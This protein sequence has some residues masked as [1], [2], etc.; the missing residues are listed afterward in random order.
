MLTIK[1]YFKKVQ[2]ID[3]DSL[4]ATLREGYDFVSE[5]TEDHTRWDYYHADEEIRA[6]IDRFLADLSDH[7]NKATAQPGAAAVKES[8]EK[9][10][11]EAAKNLI[12]PYVLRGDRMEALNKSHLSASGKE[13]SASIAGGKIN[14]D[15]VKGVPVSYK[16][17]LHS[18]YTELLEEAGMKPPAPQRSPRKTKLKPEP[19]AI[20]KPRTSNKNAAP[21]ERIDD[22]VRFI[23]R[24]ALLHGR[25]KM[26]TQ[27]LNFI[28]AL[29]KAII[30]RR[31]RKADKYADQISY[32]QTG[33]LKLYNNMGRSITIEVKP[34]VLDEFLKIA[35]TQQVR[36]SVSYMKR[37][38]GM[39]GKHIDKEKAKR[40]HK[41]IGSAL[42][43]EKIGKTD[44]N[45][46]KIMRVRTSLK[47]FIDKAKPADSLQLHSAVLNGIRETLD[48]CCCEGKKK[49]S[50]NG[51]AE[52][53][54]LAAPA[55]NEVMNS[56]DFAGMQFETLGF[57]G[58]WK[59]FIGDP[60]QGFTAMVTGKPKMGKS[61]LCA[62]F[63]GYLAR[64]HGETL[65][66]AGEEKLGATLQQKID[67]VKHP[68][69]HVA[70]NLPEDLSPYSFIVLD[71][72][73]RLRL[74]PER[75]RELKA[76]YPGKSFIYVYQVTKAGTFRG[77]NEAQHDVDVVIEVPEKGRA[78]QFGRF[79]QG[80]ELDI[81]TPAE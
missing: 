75:L 4:P 40:L 37:Y 59:E 77:P 9:E 64:N 12:R 22:A 49:G 63:A 39:Q 16:F 1:N 76:R 58:K 72:V 78:I 5:V 15:K 54:T 44:P 48:G 79:N 67:A 68:C 53:E 41:L 60:A 71:S 81:F 14:V 19:P 18:I 73:T 33:L 11:R 8:G 35:G 45:R 26:D 23:K 28:N 69:L 62:D 74:L 13:S 43:T 46:D 25:T 30:E 6:M 65:F 55:D 7:L 42:D 17:P 47:Q 2:D 21:V 29:Q 51:I 32:I 10:A 80:G 36:L 50:L 57:M 31:I 52:Q 27:I 61:Y 38:I 34:E 20:T 66:V 24:Y 56:V 70:G 3:Y